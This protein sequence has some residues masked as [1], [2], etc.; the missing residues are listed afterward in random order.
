M[1]LA[2][3]NETIQLHS[4]VW[5]VQSPTSPVGQAS[6]D[7]RSIMEAETSRVKRHS[8]QKTSLIVTHGKMSQKQRKKLASQRQSVKVDTPETEAGN[9]E[10]EKDSIPK[11]PLYAWGAVPK[12]PSAKSFRELQ[13]EDEKH[14]LV[15]ARRSASIVQATSPP[16]TLPQVSSREKMLSWG[17]TSRVRRMSEDEISTSPVSSPQSPSSEILC[18]WKQSP[19]PKS[20]SPHTVRFADIMQAE[21]K[22]TETL[23]KNMKKPFHLIQIEERAIQ[24]LLTHYCAADNPTEYISVGRDSSMMATPVWKK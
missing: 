5:G 7:L 19:C 2:E 8:H 18:P 17:I 24:E 9:K 10:S 23:E 13:L 20:P 6:T 15:N 4:T 12:S 16:P 22:Q 11:S 3:S 21:V 14:Q 1:D